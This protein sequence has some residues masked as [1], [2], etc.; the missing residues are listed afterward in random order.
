MELIAVSDKVRKV[1]EDFVPG[2]D[3]SAKLESLMRANLKHLL[4]DC[5]DA[6]SRFEAKYGLT[7]SE[8]AQAWQE[9]AIADSYSHE[10]ERDFM[11]WESY[12][13]EK[14]DL[15]AALREFDQAGRAP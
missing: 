4:T 3:L 9:G 5:N 2:E 13:Q 1:L 7:F 10:V 15:L 14:E 6:L 11:E 8:F 12:Q